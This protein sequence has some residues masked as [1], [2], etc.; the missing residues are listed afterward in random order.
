T[1]ADV[2]EDEV[3]LI[4][5]D[6]VVDDGDDVVVDVDGVVDDDDIVVVIF[7]MGKHLSACSL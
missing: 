4:D 6:E 5:D 1:C 7:N 3:K 2:D